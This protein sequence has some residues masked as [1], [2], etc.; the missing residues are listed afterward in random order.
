MRRCSRAVCRR[1]RGR[2]TLCRTTPSLHMRR[3]RA[4]RLG[5]KSHDRR[6][7]R[8]CGKSGKRAG[9]HVVKYDGSAY[10]PGGGTDEFHRV[11]GESP[12]I[13]G[14]MHGVVDKHKRDYDHDKSYDTEHNRESLY[15]AVHALH[16]CRIGQSHPGHPLN[17]EIRF[18]MTRRESSDE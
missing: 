1:T 11:Y 7:K 4:Y 18:S 9:Q 13:D 6:K 10:E 8:R 15:V 3:C 12:R 5:R 2:R 16:H 17:P 14:K